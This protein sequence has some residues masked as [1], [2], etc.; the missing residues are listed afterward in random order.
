MPTIKSKTIAVDFDGTCVTHA[1]PR[2][3]DDIGAHLVL[4]A[5]VEQGHKLILWTMRSGA[6]LE[7][8]IQWFMAH[9]IPL[10]GVQTNPT[11]RAW[12]ESPKCYAELYI[13]DAALGIPLH[14]PENGD[15]PFVDWA[16]VARLLQEKGYL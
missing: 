10:Y 12:T 11:Q 13:D 1:Y 3:G 8:A 6:R 9:N 2:V 7:E 16:A 5:L 14:H 4:L 15:R